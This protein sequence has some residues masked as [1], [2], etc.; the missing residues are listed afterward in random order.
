MGLAAPPEGIVVGA[1]WARVHGSCVLRMGWA[2]LGM[3]R[4]L[5]LGVPPSVLSFWREV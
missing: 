4:A 3:G 5:A 2:S 1:P